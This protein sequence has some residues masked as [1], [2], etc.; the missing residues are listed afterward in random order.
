MNIRSLTPNINYQQRDLIFA[1]KYESR[2]CMSKERSTY[3]HRQNGK[4]D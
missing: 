3:I 2:G 4:S 1:E